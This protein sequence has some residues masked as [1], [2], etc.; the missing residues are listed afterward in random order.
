MDGENK[1][2]FRKLPKLRADKGLNKTELASRARVSVTTIREAE[3]RHGKK[4]ETLMKIF[5]ALNEP[6]LYNGTLV[7]SDYVVSK[8]EA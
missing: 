7:A 1:F 3:K 2:E 6:D 8:S 5:N 4:Q